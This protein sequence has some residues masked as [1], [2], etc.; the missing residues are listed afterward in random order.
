MQ[1]FLQVFGELLR[2]PRTRTSRV[3]SSRKYHG[4]G[5]QLIIPT[6]ALWVLPERALRREATG[7]A[8]SGTFREQM[9][10]SRQ[11]PCPQA[12]AACRDVPER[13]L[14]GRR[15]PGAPAPQEDDPGRCE[16][17]FD[18]LGALPAFVPARILADLWVEPDAWTLG[19]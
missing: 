9:L 3:R 2:I 15:A 18:P 14:T 12:E 1:Y 17:Q 4:P 19:L 5:A 16:A 11:M 8:G 6:D 10:T 13:S 7:V